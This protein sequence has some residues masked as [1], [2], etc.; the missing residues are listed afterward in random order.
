M[1]VAMFTF[2]D[3]ASSSEAKDAGRFV[4]V[5]WCVQAHDSLRGRG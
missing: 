1:L 5:G 2:G 4:M 3:P